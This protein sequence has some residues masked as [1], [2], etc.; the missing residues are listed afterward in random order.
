MALWQETVGFG[1]RLLLGSALAALQRGGAPECGVVYPLLR[2]LACCPHRLHAL[3]PPPPYPPGPQ[4][5]VEVQPHQGGPR[6]AVGGAGG[7]H[8]HGQ[9]RVGGGQGGEGELLRLSLAGLGGG[10]QES[11]AAAFAS[12]YGWANKMSGWCTWP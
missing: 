1:I 2:Q 6:R 3:V 9:L 8:G 10:E 12:G 11:K 4:V 5:A 7:Q